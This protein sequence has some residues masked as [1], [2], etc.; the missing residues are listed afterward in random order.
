MV[1][2]NYEDDFEDDIEE[3]FEEGLERDE[4][5]RII[6]SLCVK[7]LQIAAKKK[8]KRKLTKH[9]VS[10]LEDKIGDYIDWYNAIENCIINNL[11]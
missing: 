10:I 11:S 3:D 7:D 9:E 4:L 5:E 8:L 1:T 6:Y 2:D